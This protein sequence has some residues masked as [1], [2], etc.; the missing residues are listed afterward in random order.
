MAQREFRHLGIAEGF[1]WEAPIGHSDVAPPQAVA[2]AE[3]LRAMPLPREAILAL[4]Q[5]PRTLVLEVAPAVFDED[6]EAAVI[7]ASAF[8]AGREEIGVAEV[9]LM[10]SICRALAGLG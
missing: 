9:Q 6:G 2:A 7:R 3:A 8:F 10:R 5:E 4:L 1:H